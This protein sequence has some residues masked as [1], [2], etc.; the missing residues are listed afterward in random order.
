MQRHPFTMY[1][2]FRSKQVNLERRIT[3]YYRESH[4]GDT[5]IKLVRLM[6]IRDVLCVVSI[7]KPCF[8]LVRS[9]YLNHQTETLKKYFFYFRAY[10]SKQKWACLVL[11]FYPELPKYGALRVLQRAGMIWAAAVHR[12]TVP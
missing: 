11:L 8:K 6:Q 9:L 7:D 10:F 2:I 5:V 4:D 1:T 12:F 3:K